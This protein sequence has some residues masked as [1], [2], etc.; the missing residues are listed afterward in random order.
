MNISEMYLRNCYN[1]SDINEHLPALKTYSTGCDLVVE[2][3]VRSIVST[4]AFLDA[5]PK[6]LIS[7]DIN[8]PNTCGGNLDLVKKLCELENI[9]FEF[10][11]GD[12]T[13]MEIPECDLLFID[14]WHV[15]DQLKKELELHSGKVKKYII[16]HDTTTF[17]IV[18]ETPTYRGLNFAIEE[19]LAV[20][21]NWVIEKVYTNN[22]GLTILKRIP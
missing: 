16:F 8:H 3:G 13:K 1:Q 20:N 6:K 15:Y 2:M 22:N 17:G 7:I 21:K 11:Q 12:T 4:W 18:G 19:F 5:R 10:I 9:N 14:T